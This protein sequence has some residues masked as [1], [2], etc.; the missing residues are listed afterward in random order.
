MRVARAEILQWFGLFAAALIWSTQLVVG[1]GLTVARCS[2]AGMHWGIGLDT[3]EIVLMA[4]GAV[5]TLAAEAAALTV[6]LATRDVE[7]DDPP[8]LGRRHFFASAAALGN[9]LFLVIILLS[10][11][12]AIVHTPC[13][14][15]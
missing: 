7:E 2:A 14:Q 9:V 3:W 8:P 6:F 13:H 10:G 15:A 11:I 1:F 5:V 4:I 12:G